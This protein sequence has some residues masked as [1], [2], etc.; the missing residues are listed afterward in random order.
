[1]NKSDFAGWK[2][3]FS[4]TF[5]QTVKQKAY[6]IF[7]VI[8]SIVAL[9]YSTATTLI[10][11]YNDRKE[12]KATMKEIVVFDETGLGVDYSNVFTS[13]QY[14]EI[15]ITTASGKT[16][17]EWEKA[18]EEEENADT[19]L[20]QVTF[21]QKEKNYHLLFIQGK[22]VK[23]SELAKV[24]FSDEFC[25]F[26][27]KARMDAV[28]ISKEQQDYIQ[29]EI[30]REVKSLSEDGEVI[31]KEKESISFNE[32]MIT[33]VMLMICMMM[34]NV[35]GNQI[36]L[37]IVTEKSSRVLEYLV[38]NVRPLALIVGKLLATIVTSSLQ[39]IAVGFC[40][41]ASPI[42]S[43]ILT[44]RLSK[45]LF[46][47]VES[48][49]TSAALADETLANSIRMIHGIKMEFVILALVFM[50]LGIVFY[51]IIAGL[52]GASVSKMDEMQETMTLFQLMMIVGCYG[53][54]GLCIMQISGSANPMLSKVLSICPITSPFLVP[55]NMLLGKMSWTLI[56]ASFFAMLLV[57]VLLFV[58]T[59]RVYEAMIFYNGKAL[60]IKDILAL[61]SSKKQ[62]VVKEEVQN[63]K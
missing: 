10:G 27:E 6:G 14:K 17:E 22:N 31:E 46:G 61:A 52:L 34:I 8:F 60:K 50:V 24:A 56:L 43:N 18:L 49:E 16:M 37:S 51:G 25:D 38:L 58:L 47:A 36:A 5:S 15:K 59:A 42:I 4:F 32:Y 62:L 39:M 63:E 33:L 45:W 57:I 9:F 30:V 44:P 19:M 48:A 21:N 20:I 55:C 35:S 40:Y 26:F 1:M 2:E 23:L 12:A 54:M 11:Q 28:E 13:K 29:R 3:V 7:L 41:A 53:D